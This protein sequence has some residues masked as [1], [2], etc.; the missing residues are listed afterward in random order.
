MCPIFVIQFSLS[1]F[2]KPS[3]QQHVSKEENIE[4]AKNYGGKKEEIKPENRQNK[5]SVSLGKKGS[6]KRDLLLSTPHK[7][8][9][10]QDQ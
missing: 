5:E 10:F 2:N 9:S 4:S 6:P 1:N 8:Y 7:K 3:Q